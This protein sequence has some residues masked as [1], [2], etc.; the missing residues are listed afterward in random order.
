[1]SLQLQSSREQ[2]NDDSICVQSVAL[3]VVEEMDLFHHL[4]FL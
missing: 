3:E 4:S 1:M 2:A